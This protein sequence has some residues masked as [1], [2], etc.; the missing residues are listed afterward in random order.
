MCSSNCD[1]LLDFTPALWDNVVQGSHWC[2]FDK[3]VV[4]NDANEL[5]ALYLPHS[6]LFGPIPESIG[7]LTSLKE[8]DLSH[9][10]K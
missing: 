8:L 10:G 4:C 6:G 2:C 1:I 3:A 5:I 7:G 9:N